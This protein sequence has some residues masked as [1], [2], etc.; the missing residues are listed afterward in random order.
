MITE[1]EEVGNCVFGE[2]WHALV[3]TGCCVMPNSC[4]AMWYP[5]K[6]FSVG[7]LGSWLSFLSLLKL[8]NF[9][10]FASFQR[11]QILCTFYEGM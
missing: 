10:I 11:M 5:K 1:R 8:V 4:F 6:L 3:G 7:I 2:S 9:P